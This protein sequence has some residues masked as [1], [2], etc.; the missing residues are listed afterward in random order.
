VGSIS[1]IAILNYQ[2]LRAVLARACPIPRG[3]ALL[4]IDQI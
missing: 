2:K 1:E 4:L 3:F